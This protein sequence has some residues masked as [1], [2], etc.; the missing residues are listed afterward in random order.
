MSQKA[1][2]AVQLA[3]DNFVDIL[4]DSYPNGEGEDPKVLWD[5]LVHLA[6]IADLLNLEVEAP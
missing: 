6:Y 1:P 2:E 4:R 3:F 5:V